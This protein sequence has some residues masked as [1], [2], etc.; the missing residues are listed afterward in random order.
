M[1]NVNAKKYYGD[2]LVLDVDRSFEEGKIYAIIGNNGSGKSTFLKALSKQISIKGT[3]EA[4]KNCVFM[5]Q[6][7]YNFDLSVKNNILIYTSSK[8]QEKQK[9]AEDLMTRI[10]IID[11]K[12][13][14]A[15]KI[16]G[17]E[18]QKTALI[19]TLMQASDILLLDEPT[20]SMDMQSSQIAEELIKEYKARNNSTVFIV[21]HSISEA[22]RISDEIL[23]FDNGKIVE[24]GK[25][26]I[27]NP[28]TEELKQ[29]LNNK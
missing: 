11:L 10:G 19:R 27:K 26:I 25:D 29:F 4:S 9:L 13:K 21:T 7:T 2:M 20:S 6:I 12:K 23:F 28:Q 16:S 24:S 18:A 3:I 1:V 15:K 8:N 22:E 5:P 14:N 17:G